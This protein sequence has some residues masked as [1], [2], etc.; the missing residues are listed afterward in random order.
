MIKM[1]DVNSD[2]EEN[3]S[4][5]KALDKMYRKMEEEEKIKSLMRQLL[6]PDAYERMMNIKASNEDL[7]MQFA[8]LLV[9]LVQSN[10][11]RGRITDEQLKGLL[12]RFTAR[13]EPTINIKHK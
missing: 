6:D 2:D 13:H 10:Q 11:I 12:S 3:R 5:K 1:P 8:S 7:Y 4:Y 9:Q